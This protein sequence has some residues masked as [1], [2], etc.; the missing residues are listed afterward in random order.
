MRGL[1]SSSE[2]FVDRLLAC[3]PSESFAEYTSQ[4]DRIQRAERAAQ[5]ARDELARIQ[6]QLE[7]AQT[8]RD[9]KDRALADLENSR[10]SRRGWM[11]RTLRLVSRVQS[12]RTQYEA[13]DEE[14]RKLNERV[15]EL[16]TQWQDVTVRLT[17]AERLI[18]S[19]RQEVETAQAHLMVEQ[20]KVRECI[21]EIAVREVE[22][23]Q[24]DAQI[25]GLQNQNLELVQLSEEREGVIVEMQIDLDS[26]RSRVRERDEQLLDEEAQ[27]TRQDGLIRGLQMQKME[28]LHH[29]EEREDAMQVIRTELD[30][31]KDRVWDR[32]RQIEEQAMQIDELEMENEHLHT[33]VQ[34]LEE[35]VQ[36]MYME[37]EERDE[38]IGEKDGVIEER[39]S[40]I[41]ELREENEAMRENY[42]VMMQGIPAFFGQFV[43]P[44]RRG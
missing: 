19:L 39:E 6:L 3:Q 21:M 11:V 40:A 1:G 36:S 28:L 14:R 34:Q 8:L 24:R 42:G 27:I 5:T 29:E 18:E 4:E 7:D 22:I 26:E 41:G 2:L 25:Q 23:G 10:V 12:S 16:L 30:V 33:S 38:I 35:V 43:P 15:G 44:P 17:D 37:V 20:E 9:D 13:L 32:D 31:E